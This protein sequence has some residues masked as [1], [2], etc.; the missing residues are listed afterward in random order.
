MDE[1]TPNE[2]PEGPVT[3]ADVAGLFND[4]RSMAKRLLYG[5]GKARSVRPTALVNSALRRCRRVDQDWSELTWENREL[6]FASI[7]REMKR[8]LCDYA[9]K[10]EALK[11][12]KLEYVEP[13]D[14]DLYD[15][16]KEAEERP[17][18]V[19][20]LDE[21]LD[22]LSRESQELLVVINHHYFTG[23]T[24]LEIGTLL[25][26]SE[27]SVKRRLNRARLLLHKKILEIVNSAG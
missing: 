5:E 23:M 1:S 7:H 20:A 16:P 15:L 18:I 2:L 12:P 3:I 26:L 19:V 14:F 25:A 17:Q 13:E 24:V 10:R 22:W 11:R 8:A 27:S 4:L 6:F 9:R 21:A